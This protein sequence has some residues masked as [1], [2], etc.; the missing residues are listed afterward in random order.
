MDEKIH[1]FFPAFRFYTKKVDAFYNEQSSSERSRSGASALRTAF[2]SKTH[3]IRNIFFAKSYRSIG[4]LRQYRTLTIFHIKFHRFSET[5]LRF[6][7]CS[8]QM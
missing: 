2:D 6:D 8:Y 7:Q 4:L 3:M 5:V 1:S